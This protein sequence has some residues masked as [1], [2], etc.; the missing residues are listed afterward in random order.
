MVT[1]SLDYNA[2]W[3]CT[4]LNIFIFYYHWTVPCAS[5]H[6]EMDDDVRGDGG[7]TRQERKP[8]ALAE[9]R[10]HYLFILGPG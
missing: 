10:D 5:P 6:S 8:P 9:S 2:V 4:L 3:L 7:R 1:V